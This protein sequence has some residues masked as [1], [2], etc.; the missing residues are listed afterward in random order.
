MID[1]WRRGGGGQGAEVRGSSGG[2]GSILKVH[3]GGITLAGHADV[4][5]FCC[6]NRCH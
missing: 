5:T 4:I 6:C 2:A 1:G 3:R